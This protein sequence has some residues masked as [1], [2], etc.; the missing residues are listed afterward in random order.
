M[1]S[2]AAAGPRG[3][4]L[5]RVMWAMRSDPLLPWLQ[6]FRD[7]GDVVQARVPGIHQF[8]IYRPEHVEHVLVTNQDNYG[9]GAHYDIYA[10]ALGRGLVTS[11]GELWR[12]QRRLVQP[13]FAKRHLEV[14]GAG[15]LG[16]A[17]HMLAGWDRRPDG[18]ELDVAAAMLSLTFDVVGRTL[19]GS[20]LTDRVR[21]TVDAAMAEVLTELV[22]ASVSPL[23]WI[24]SAAPGVTM[25]QALRL[26]PLPQRR[27]R[28][29][30]ERLDACIAELIERRRRDGNGVGRDLL[31][32]LLSAR[33][34]D[35]APMPD[36]QVR[37]ELV[38]FLMAGHETIANAIAW[39]WA[40]LSRHP[41]ARERVHDELDRQLAGRTPS[42]ADADALPWTRAVV[43][44]T[45][46]LYPPI[47]GVPRQ[48]LADDVIGDHHVP[49]G[50]TVAV[51]IYATHRDPTAWPNPEG[52]DPERFLGPGRPARGAY[53]PFAAGRRGCI[54]S[55][56]ALTE[57]V[58]LTAAIA[59]RY[60]L[61]LTPGVQP[62]PEALLTLRPR[63]GVPMAAR[64]R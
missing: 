18:F 60:R 10:A 40:L 35:G 26:R 25:E 2:V 47:W 14:F 36:R 1:T 56:F 42:Y 34:A 22:A 8:A 45:L 57:A 62:Q 19:F 13:M 43:Q 32:L 17:E 4:E 53:V 9:K 52:F 55:T 63:N 38:T 21:A 64:R 12:R 61:D 6:L 46:R 24:A 50:A 5:A 20:D 48:A 15:M 59:Q 28:S 31:D 7:Y 39:T 49:A 54:G 16:A 3:V 23:T 29:T 33:D 44:E 37:D 41:D 51:L 11:G 30:L 27:L 58:L